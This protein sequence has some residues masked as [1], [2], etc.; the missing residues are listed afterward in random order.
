VKPHAV[1]ILLRCTFNAHAELIIYNDTGSQQ[2]VRG[3]IER[4][5]RSFGVLI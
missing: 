1:I 5:V 2:V 3:R 4:T